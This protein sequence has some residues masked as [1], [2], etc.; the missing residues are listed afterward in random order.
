MQIKE[1]EIQN[2][3]KILLPDGCHFSDEAKSLLSCWESK[4]VSACPGSGKTT[5]LLAKLKLLADR[6]PLENGAG[7]CVLSHTNVA[8]NEIKTKMASY[9]AKLMRYPNYF[10]TIQSFVNQFVTLP[11]LKRKFGIMVQEVDDRTYAEHLYRIIISS[12]KY[13]RLK[14]L[15]NSRYSK[16]N[17]YSDKA[18]YISH[19]NLN[20]DNALCIGDIVVAGSKSESAIQFKLALI[21]LTEKEGIIK[22]TDSY[23]YAEEAVEELTDEFTNLFSERFQY[24]FIDEYQD[25]S[26][27]QR[28][29]LAKLFDSQKSCI[30]R[31]GD[32][33]QAIYETDKTGC[34]DWQ[35][36]EGCFSL[37]IS[38]RYGQEIA[39]VLHFLRTGTE[40]IITS[41]GNIGYKPVL[42]VYNM[43]CI[44]NV[45]ENFIIQLNTHGLTD[46][47]G[48]YKVIG[49]IQDNSVAG[50]TIGSYWKDYNFA[51]RVNTSFNYWTL[52]NEI[53]NYIVDGQIYLAEPIIRKLLCRVFHYARIT[54][55]STG[56]KYTP[57]TIKQKLDK[58][59]FDVYR[60]GIMKIISSSTI[61]ESSI[62]LAFR[63]LMDNFF[64]NSPKSGKEIMNGLPPH[65][66]AKAQDIPKSN[67]KNN[68]FIDQEYGRLIQF[69]TVHG[70]KGETHNATLYL[71]TETRGGSDIGRVLPWFGIGKIVRKPI[72]EHSRKLVYVGFSR[73][74]ELLCLAVK[75]TTFDKGI[76]FFKN[77]DIVDLRK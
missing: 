20:R 50:T 49:N 16:S 56:K 51:R 53:Y 22:Y 52:I 59:F 29:A 13:F 70:I 31:I 71:E 15:I 23:K 36:M 54:N 39:D 4:D 46:K 64:L 47:N 40:E 28:E 32:P 6:M 17:H 30:F 19:L 41:K 69:D 62:D 24:V 73:P 45:V 72:Y 60:D 48:I 35:P 58:D 42:F 10:G 2:I 5:I 14:N 65:F 9:T 43:D 44:S 68:F 21:E 34:G 38:N 1:D 63:N 66:I 67:V 61:T 7:I 33:D 27:I 74:K 26:I 75:E 55:A 18:D 25:C 57:Y 37:N 3:E 11:Y 12:K 8:V 77:W 76:E